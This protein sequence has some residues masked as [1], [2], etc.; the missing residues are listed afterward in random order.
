[1]Y[2]IRIRTFRHSIETG[3]VELRCIACKPLKTSK[4]VGKI[5]G[6]YDFQL[7]WGS[8]KGNSGTENLFLKKLEKVVH[9]FLLLHVDFIYML[10]N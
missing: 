10:L 4:N 1:M 3:K 2:S 7:G 8:A 9:V 5:S 6:Q